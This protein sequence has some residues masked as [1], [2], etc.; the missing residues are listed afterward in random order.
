MKVD[1]NEVMSVI[2]SMDEYC[3]QKA[4]VKRLKARLLK[5]KTAG[6]EG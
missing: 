1:L 3:S 5:L 4:Y 2:D 6:M